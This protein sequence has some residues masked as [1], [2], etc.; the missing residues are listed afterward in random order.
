MSN[1]AQSPI[2]KTEV[3]AIAADTFKD[4]SEKEK[5]EISQVPVKGKTKNNKTKKRKNKRNRKNI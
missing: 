4:A 3:V 2:D 5:S 1:F